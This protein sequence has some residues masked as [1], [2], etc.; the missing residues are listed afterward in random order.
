MKKL[1]VIGVGSP[2]GQ[3]DLAWQTIDFLKLQF[4]GNDIEFTK[5]DRPGSQLIAYLEGVE[6]V[7]ILDSLEQS[8]EESV[9]ALNIDQLQEENLLFSSHGFGVAESLQ[10]AGVM[11]LLPAKLYILGLSPG[12]R[13][14]VLAD[15]CAA[16]LTSILA[17]DQGQAQN[18]DVV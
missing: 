15:R 17:D 4:R 12:S 18:A 2:H 14:T 3:D 6:K 16:M 11:Q 1:R 10:L 5:L 9:V 7:V 13:V 8:A